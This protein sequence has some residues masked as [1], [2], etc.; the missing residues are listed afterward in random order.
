[1]RCFS[2]SAFSSCNI[3]LNSD[4]S[5]AA[6]VLPAMCAALVPCAASESPDHF[7]RASNF[8][9]PFS[10][11]PASDRL[12][13]ANVA[14]TRTASFALFVMNITWSSCCSSQHFLGV[15][16]SLYSSGPNH[17]IKPKVH[18][19]DPRAVRTSRRRQLPTRT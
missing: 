13:L 15:T 4:Q 7:L 19:V 16:S 8:P 11:R 14:T 17:L 2:F 10:H 5:L 1:M 12:S 9:F 18:C 3:F 6:S